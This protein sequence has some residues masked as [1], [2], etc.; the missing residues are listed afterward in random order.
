MPV[1]RAAKRVRRARRHAAIPPAPPLPEGPFGL[2]LADPPWQM[3]APSCASSPEDHY[4]TMS[5]ADIQCAR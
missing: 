4:P 5:L 2:I 1:N 3:G